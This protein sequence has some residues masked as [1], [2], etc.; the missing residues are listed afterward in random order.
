MKQYTREYD[1]WDVIV[2]FYAVSIKI[3]G[4]EDTTEWMWKLVKE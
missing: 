1:D 3:A 2:T 4:N